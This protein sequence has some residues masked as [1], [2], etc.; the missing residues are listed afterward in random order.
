MDI[1]VVLPSKRLSP[2]SPPFPKTRKYTSYIRYISNESFSFFLFL[3]FISEL[4]HYK[5]QRVLLSRLPK[6]NDPRF[7]ILLISRVWYS[8]SSVYQCPRNRSR[9]MRRWESPQSYLPRWMESVYELEKEND[10]S[11][12]YSQHR[13]KELF[14]QRSV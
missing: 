14:Q 3:Y 9:Q 7:L 6:N 5:N 4:T 11:W 8:V 2:Q 1:I 10:V 13:T 12:L